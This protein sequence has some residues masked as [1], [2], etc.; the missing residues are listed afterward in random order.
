VDNLN[1]ASLLWFFGEMPTVDQV[2]DHA[3]NR[4]FGFEPQV[5]GY[6]LMGRS[7]AVHLVIDGDELFAAFHLWRQAH[8]AHAFPSFDKRETKPETIS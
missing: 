3:M 7:V 4:A 2:L 6:F 5:V 1:R 8:G